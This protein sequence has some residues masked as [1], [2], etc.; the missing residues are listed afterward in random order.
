MTNRSVSLSAWRWSARVL[1]LLV[2]GI[3]LM[4]AFR[5]GLNLAMFLRST[6]SPDQGVSA[7]RL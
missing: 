1:S 6:M 2:I 4:F 7:Y 3:I 5:E